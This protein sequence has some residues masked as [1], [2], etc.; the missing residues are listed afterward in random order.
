MS[1]FFIG[2]LYIY[3]TLFDSISLY[4]PNTTHAD[5]GEF[6]VIGK[7]FKGINDEQLESLIKLLD[8]FIMNNK[9]YYNIIE[10]E[11]IPE[12]FI[13]QIMVFM[14]DMSN[15]N[16][17]N[18]EKQNLLLTCYKNF[19]EENTIDKNKFQQ[20]NKLLKCN[21]LFNKNKIEHMLIPKYKEWMKIYN[22]S[23]AKT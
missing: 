18:L 12:T 1:N 16:I 17:M 6:Y 15:L 11:Y 4:K 8:N 5:N 13:N 22:L 14:E 20:T 10:P 23:F 19:T 9:Y 7:G 3:Y 2:Y 21:N